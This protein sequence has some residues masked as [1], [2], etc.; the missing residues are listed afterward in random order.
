M[1]FDESHAPK[2]T[3]VEQAEPDDKEIIVDTLTRAFWDLRS[4]AR[5]TQ[6]L[7]YTVFSAN[8]RH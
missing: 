4:L 8:D 1:I 2:H 6:Q 5:M 3:F 7:L